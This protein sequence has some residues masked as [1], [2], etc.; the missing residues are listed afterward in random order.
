MTEYG[1]TPA[2]ALHGGLD[3]GALPIKG[4]AGRTV[5]ALI[6]AADTARPP[7]RLALGSTAYTSIRAALNGRLDA[8]DAQKEQA[9]AADV[10]AG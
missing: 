4:D 7:L 5:D 3:S 10:D 2:G 1:G 6:A 9:F 8:L